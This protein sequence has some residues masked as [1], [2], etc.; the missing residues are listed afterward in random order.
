[1]GF[2]LFVCQNLISC[3]CSQGFL[4]LFDSVIGNVLQDRSVKTPNLMH[5]EFFK[6]NK[7]NHPKQVN[8]GLFFF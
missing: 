2:I 4:G 7:K 6:S 5:H 3:F 8:F 1:M